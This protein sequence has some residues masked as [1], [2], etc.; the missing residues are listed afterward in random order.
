MNIRNTIRAL[1]IVGPAVL[2]S[3]EL[4]DPA[5]I[6]TSTAAGA[7]H[8][9][10][11]LWAAFYSGILLIVIQGVSARLGVVTGKTLAENIHYTY[12]KFYSIVLLVVSIFLDFATLTA[13]VIGLSLAISFIFKIPYPLG[14]IASILITV[15]LVYFS[16]YDKLEKV[17]MLLVTIIFFAYLY[18]IF[19]LNIP[20]DKLA[21]NLL[22]PSL[23]TN[24]F[25]YAE[26]VIGASIMPTYITL[27]SGLVY[28]KGWAHHHDKSIEELVECEDKVESK[29]KCVT[30]A[31]V[32]SIF[33][34]LMGTILNIVIIAT[35]AVLLR[36]KEVNSFLDIAFPFY[37]KLGNIGLS[38]FALAFI[39]AGIAA[40]TTV[41]L[42]SVYNMFGY[43]GFKERLNKRRF[44][45]LFI[46]WVIIAG[47]GS[48][49]PNQIDIMV[50]TQYLNG[51][52]LPFIII[53]LILL[54][55]DKNIMGKFKLGNTMTVLALATV[56]VTTLLFITNLITMIIH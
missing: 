46:L 24:S 26:A 53:P 4:F 2:I 18:F 47:V 39:C 42:A 38:I 10:G 43:L 44:R 16:P 50:F 13:E 40:I 25:Y 30:N 31:R 12:G 56:L 11:V 14:V 20:L 9:Y 51:A 1:S 54:T 21:Y 36:G 15:L 32:D 7:A 17:I 34:L 55:R 19:T 33:S 6:V 5:S 28:E 35:A 8:G 52:L 23:N 48:F 22:I 45:L 29:E 37:S 3:V 27:H 41:G 49:L